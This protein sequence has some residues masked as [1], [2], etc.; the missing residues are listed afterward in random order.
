MILRMTVSKEK[1]F[2]GMITSCIDVTFLLVK[3]VGVRHLFA[4]VSPRRDILKC[5][6]LSFL[7]FSKFFPQE[8]LAMKHTFILLTRS[9]LF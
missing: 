1:T 4:L 7:Y 6:T 2:R 3:S 8:I 9:P 5:D